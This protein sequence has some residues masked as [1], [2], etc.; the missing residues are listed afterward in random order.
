MNNKNKLIIKYL[1][2]I[3]K[4][5]SDNKLEKRLTRT[6]IANDQCYLAKVQRDTKLY[7]YINIYI[8]LH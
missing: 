5:W 1:N 7:E 8:S 3:E 2:S 6:P 4:A